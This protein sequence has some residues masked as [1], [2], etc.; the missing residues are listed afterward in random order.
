MRCLCCERN[1]AEIWTFMLFFRKEMD[2]YRKCSQLQENY[3][4][5]ILL[6]LAIFYQERQLQPWMI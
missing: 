4:L 2:Y 3:G 5:M 1:A 6:S